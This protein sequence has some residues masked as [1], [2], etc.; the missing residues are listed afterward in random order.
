MS[1]VYEDHLI[2]WEWHKGISQDRCCVLLIQGRANVTHTKAAMSS[3]FITIFALSTGLRDHH[4]KSYISQT[5]SVKF[6]L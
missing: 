3:T 5:V 1:Q 4:P 6:P 2:L